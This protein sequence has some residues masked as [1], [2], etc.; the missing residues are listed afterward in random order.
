MEP[1]VKSQRSAV[2]G[3]VAAADAFL[4][5]KSAVDWSS[6]SKADRQ[7]MLGWMTTLD[8]YNNEFIG[9]GHCP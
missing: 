1:V 7:K 8:N 9:P 3:T 6:L 4:A 5:T 2:A